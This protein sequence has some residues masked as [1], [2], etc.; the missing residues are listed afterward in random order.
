[1]W[2]ERNLPLG[3][4]VLGKFRQQ[5]Y[6]GEQRAEL[7]D[8]R[9]PAGNASRRTEHPADRRGTNTSD[10]NSTYGGDGGV[11]IGSTFRRV[12][13]A[14]KFWDSSILLSQR[15]NQDSRVHLRPQPAHDGQE[16][17]AVAD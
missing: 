14:A 9:L 4:P 13:Y 16:G 3:G 6:F 1:M 17:C 12:L 5:I 11:G 2:A 10:Q 7:L 8:R 15:V